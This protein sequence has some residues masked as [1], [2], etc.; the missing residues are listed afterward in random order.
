MQLRKGRI[1]HYFGDRDFYR[2]ILFVAL[3]IMLQQMIANAMGFVDGV[4]VGQI[5]ARGLASVTI[6]N[7]YFMI[8][9]S[10]LFGVTGGL[11]IFISQYFG[12]E[13]H[14]KGQG[15][16]AINVLGSG[17]IAGVFLLLISL[18]PRAVLSLF[19]SD[20]TTLQYGQ[21]YL[22]TVRFSY[23]PFAVSLACMTSLR[24]IGQTRKPL[25]ISSLAILLNSGLNFL[26]IFGNFGFPKMSIAGAGLATLISRLVEM[27]F[28]L[29]LFARGS[30][31]FDLRL[32]H[33]RQLS[34]AILRQVLHKSLPLV[35]NELLWSVGTATL[36]WTYCQIDEAFIASLTV[37][38]ITANL[39]FVLNGGLGAAISVL[40]G[41]RL[42]ASRFAEARDNARRILTLWALA[43]LFAALVVILLAG[44]IPL[45]FNLEPAIRL[46]ASQ[47]LRIQASIYV[48]IT[49]NLGLFFILRIGGDTRAT[50]I[51]DSVLIW[52]FVIP[53][54]AI[55]SLL[56]KPGIVIFYLVIQL[57]ELLKLFIARH[58]FFKGR[59]LCNLT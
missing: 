42:G 33:F 47:L 12:A 44:K 26:L 4:M 25:L 41:A 1:S 17:A 52:L 15:L 56:V 46:L 11:G 54:A 2:E 7:K 10:L 9:Q 28:Y 23:L 13:D 35:G 53:L 50:L 51:M 48:F 31:Y 29:L 8:L 38:E 37:V 20:P 58:Y 45:L 40:V 34:S 43:V 14:E 5:D 19:V 3:P 39:V 24:S 16:F 57:T 27:I 30:E 59:W 55:L 49:L 18:F 32:F 21:D 6:A 22:N 36:F